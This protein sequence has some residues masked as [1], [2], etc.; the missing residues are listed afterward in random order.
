VTGF[1]AYHSSFVDPT[2]LGNAVIHYAVV[3]F[4][5]YDS[6]DSSDF[7]G[8]VNALNIF[9]PSSGDGT[10]TGH[11]E[12]DLGA[13]QLAPTP[14]TPPP[15][16]YGHFGQTLDSMTVAAS[17]EIAETVTDP[18]VAVSNLAFGGT[19]SQLAWYNMLNNDA[20][21]TGNVTG[22][23]G[24]LS[25]ESDT[26]INLGGENFAVQKLVNQNNQ[27]VGPNDFSGQ[28]SGFVDFFGNNEVFDRRWDGHIF[29]TVQA[30][31][32]GVW[33]AQTDV[34]AI[35]GAPLAVSDVSAVNYGGSTNIF[36]RAQNNQLIDLYNSGFGWQWQTV[37]FISGFGFNS[38]LLQGIPNTYYL[39]FGLASNTSAPTATVFQG[40]VHVFVING[41]GHIEDLAGSPWMGWNWR[42]VSLAPGYSFPVF[43]AQSNQ[44]NP[45]TTDTFSTRVS[46]ATNGSLLEVVYKDINSNIQNIE[47]NASTGAW[48]FNNTNWV[49]FN[50]AGGFQAFA[51]NPLVDGDP[52]A[53]I[54]NNTLYM[55]YSGRTATGGNA[56]IQVF[57]H[58]LGTNTWRRQGLSGLAAGAPL[59]ASGDNVEVSP[60]VIAAGSFLHVFY[61][62]GNSPIMDAADG[63]GLVGFN[64]GRIDDAFLN[65]TTGVWSNNNL[66]AGV[67]GFS[68]IHFPLVGKISGFARGNSILMFFQDPF[69]TAA[70][71]AN[72]WYNAGAFFIFPGNGE[73]EFGNYGVSELT[74]NPGPPVTRTFTPRILFTG[75]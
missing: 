70:E 64:G 65:G 10:A 45:T 55:V 13:V 15:F 22:E 60:T 35:S 68:A 26:L 36:Y 14:P 28:T 8:L 74:V 67:A 3:P 2:A 62:V 52:S 63:F 34:T 25:P 59:P 18:Y 24:D 75:P 17:H 44:F 58:V 12:T 6:D 4:H 33:S 31:G 29:Q 30:G 32:T 61:K 69:Q 49:L 73:G 40:A 19:S 42:D 21:P 20:G 39:N 43:G 57:S 5:D 54:L 51:Q 11:N 41:Y 72:Y 9:A 23:I 56:G 46:V 50:T 1:Q 38:Q 27:F 53:A 7:Q 37:E 71:E 48:T 47:F 16:Y 66:G